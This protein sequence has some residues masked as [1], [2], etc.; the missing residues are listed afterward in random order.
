MEAI[1]QSRIRYNGKIE[2][3]SRIIC[4]EFNLGDFLS[5]KI[6]TRGYEDFNVMLMTTKGEYLVKMLAATRTDED[7]R[8]YLDI[9]LKVLAAGISHPKLFKSSQGYLHIIKHNDA[10]IR[11]CVMELINGKDFYHAKLTPTIE[12]LKEVGKQAALIDNISMKPKF[13]YDAWAITNFIEEFQKKSKYL[14]TEDLALI[15]PLVVQFKNLN[16]E[17]L[18]H[19]F[20]H[21]DITKTNTIKDKEQKIWIIDFAVGNYYPRIQELSV[22]ACDLCFD[23]ED[24]E[25]SEK[26]FKAVLDE[27][28]KT[29]QLTTEEKEKLP[30]YIRLAHAMHVLCANYEKIVNNNDSDENEYFLAQGRAGLKQ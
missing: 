27:Y 10:E 6:I 22:I 29:I 13:V 19:C 24:K 16:I 3:I 11:S 26:R 17:K 8:R 5:N 7:C 4:R 14:S 21:G 1:Y 9:M 2:D 15:E 18:P 28:Q 25:K 23:R 30:I 12:D 20:A